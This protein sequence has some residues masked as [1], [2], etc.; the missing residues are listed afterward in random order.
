LSGD[1]QLYCDGPGDDG[2]PCGKPVAKHGEGKCSTHRKQLQ[3]TGEMKPIAKR[4]T[5]IERVLACADQLVQA[6]PLDDLAFDEKRA[7]LISAAKALGRSARAEAI[8]DGLKRA[9]ARG[10]QV[11]RPRKVQPA[12]IVKLLRKLKSPTAVARKLGIGRTT[13]YRARFKT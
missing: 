4:V 9:K 1:E 8:R 13:V 5:P 6:D 7:A 2:N 10:G 11:G 3:R 12:K